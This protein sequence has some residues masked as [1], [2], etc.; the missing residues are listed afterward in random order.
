MTA[1]N[2]QSTISARPAH[3]A[4]DIAD[5]FLFLQDTQEPDIDNAKLQMFLYYAQGF[6]LA[7]HGAPLYSEPVM[8]WLRG[9]VVEQ[10]HHQYRDHGISTLPRPDTLDLSN[11]APEIVTLIK[12][13]YQ[14]YGQFTTDTLRRITQQS[15]AQLPMEIRQETMGKHFRAQLAEPLERATQDG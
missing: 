12:D 3:T 9:P 11:Y 13:V 2:A 5:L 8:I 1:E 4:S 7:L 10:V 15:L 6:H 14:A